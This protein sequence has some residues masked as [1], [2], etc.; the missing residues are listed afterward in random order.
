MV[1]GGRREEG[2]GWVTRV[3]L[4]RI[5][6]DIWQNQYNIVKLKNKIKKKKTYLLIYFW[7]C[8]VFVAACGLSPVAVSGGCSLQWLLSAERGLSAHGLQESPRVGSGVVAQGL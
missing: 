7:L 2:S 3:Y 8:W 1:K 4:W 5:H 6:V